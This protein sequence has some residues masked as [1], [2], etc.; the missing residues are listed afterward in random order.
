MIEST[1]FE[2]KNILVTGSS[3]LLGSWL[4]EDLLS[5]GCNV[6]GI[7]I[8]ETK[9]DLLK[10]KNIFDKIEK[11]YIDV[12]SYKDIEKIIL[13]KKFTFIFHLAAQT[14]VTE[15]LSNPLRTLE[16]NIKGTWNLLEISRMQNIPMVLASSDKAYG[17]SDKLPYQ[18]NF[19]LNGEFPYEVSKSASDLITTMYANTYNINVATLRCGNIYGGGDLNWD[20]LIPGVIKHLIKGEI[21]ILRTK[22]NFKREWVYVK[23]VVSAYIATADAVI[24]NKNKFIAYNFASGETKSVMEVYEIIST[25]V[26]GEIIKPKIQLDSEFEI[27]DQ[28]LDSSRIKNDL[29]IES[30]FTFE[31]SILET[32][33]WYKS[34]LNQ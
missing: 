28:Q 25:L 14:Q 31:E 26:V 20:R 2:N 19:A 10:S 5:M 13:N 12:S 6:T 21:P 24:K 18:E 29:G 22:G 1:S 15:A 9:D 30:K 32:I 7:A 23:D 34:N 3:G 11:F 33:E 4:I 27:K 16:S 8:D 17:T